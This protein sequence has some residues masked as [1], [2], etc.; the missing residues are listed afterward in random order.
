MKTYNDL[1]QVKV[2]FGINRF[3]VRDMKHSYL[4]KF[5]QL[6]GILERLLV[7]IVWYS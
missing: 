7:A 2:Y 1:N 4:Q 6:F 5:A 3:P